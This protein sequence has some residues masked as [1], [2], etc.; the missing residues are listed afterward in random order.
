MAR[1]LGIVQ[2]EVAGPP[3]IDVGRYL[4]AEPKT[5]VVVTTPGARAERVKP[6]R[7]VR[8]EKPRRA[9][10]PSGAADVWTTRW[11]AVD[12]TPLGDSPQDWL[13]RMTADG[14]AAAE[15]LSEGVR[16]INHVM[17]AHRD[18]TL[19]PSLAELFPDEAL[20]RRIGY[21]S[22]E[23]AAEGRW[24]AA[25][26]LP[27]DPRISHERREALNA[28]ER[29]ADLLAGRS[30][31]DPAAPAALRARED[32]DAGRVAEAAAQLDIALRFLGPEAVRADA[33]LADAS[34]PVAE[35]AKRLVHPDAVASDADG[36]RVGA[37]LGLLERQLRRRRAK[38]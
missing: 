18:A 12:P 6:R 26:E 20:T 35:A 2:L 16:L 29:V 33:E 17:R 7:R 13:D 14:S 9:D 37:C 11:T 24:E 21:A 23:G 36:E 32:L 30:D 8:R 10:E 25:Y 5:V 3:P 31:L 19:D 34:E 1:R 27:A 4:I 28:R 15:R 22:P 38:G